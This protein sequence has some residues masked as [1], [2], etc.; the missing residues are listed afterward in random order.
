MRALSRALAGARAVGDRARSLCPIGDCLCRTATLTSRSHTLFG[1]P[2]AAVDLFASVVGWTIRI[3]CTAAATKRTSI[4][5]CDAQRPGIDNAALG[6][7]D[8]RTAQRG[9]FGQADENRVAAR[10]LHAFKAGWATFN[11]LTRADF[12]AG[13]VDA[14]AAFAVGTGFA[15][16]AGAVCRW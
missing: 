14:K 4:S 8:A 11:A 1:C 5:T 9:E 15:G 6:I 16:A 3:C 7:V 12:A 13:R 2:V 10:S